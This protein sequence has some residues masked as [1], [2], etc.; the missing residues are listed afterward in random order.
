MRR[1]SL[2]STLAQ[3]TFCVVN[4]LKQF[5]PRHAAFFG[6]ALQSRRVDRFQHILILQF[7]VR[8]LQY[9]KSCFSRLEIFTLLYLPKSTNQPTY[10]DQFSI[11]IIIPQNSA[12]DYIFYYTHQLFTYTPRWNVSTVQNVENLAKY[13]IESYILVVSGRSIF[14]YFFDLPLCPNTKCSF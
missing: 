11:L 6:I 12:Q 4:T 10:Q 13:F 5:F 7:S 2:A 14:E 9:M 3:K 1:W 8:I